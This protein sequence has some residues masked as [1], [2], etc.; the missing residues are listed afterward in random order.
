MDGSPR[1]LK[2]VWLEG[3]SV[4]LVDQRL[5]PNELK[6]LDLRDVEDVARAIETMAVRGAP[7]IGEAG[8]DEQGHWHLQAQQLGQ[9]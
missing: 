5:L 9:H 6:I 7:A 2:T 8:T 1:E 4:R 3:D